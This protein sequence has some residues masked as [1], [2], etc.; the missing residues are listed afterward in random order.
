TTFRKYFVD[1]GERCWLIR[2]DRDKLSRELTEYLKHVPENIRDTATCNMRDIWYRF[3]LPR[4]PEALFALGFVK[5]GPKFVENQIKALPVGAVGG[6]HS[7]NK[8]ITSEVV[9]ELRTKLLTPRVVAHSNTLKKIEINQL[10][11]LLQEYS[12]DVGK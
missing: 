4:T 5:K 7:R 6:I 12:R 10:N 11:S 1:K 2:S 8:S 9:R 3:K